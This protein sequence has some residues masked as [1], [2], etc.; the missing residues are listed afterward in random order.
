MNCII[1]I[2]SGALCRNLKKLRALLQVS[3]EDERD[4]TLIGLVGMHDPPRTEVEA[5]VESCFRA[6]VRLIV[7]T[8]DNKA[9]AESV[10]R[11]IGVLQGH[12]DHYSSVTGFQHLPV[13]KPF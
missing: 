3:V 6:G 13:E 9:T 8:G 1:D 4:L 7:V 12:M 10:C 11:Q 5:A 2:S